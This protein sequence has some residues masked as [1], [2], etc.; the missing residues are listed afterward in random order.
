MRSDV[1]LNHI[2]GALWDAKRLCLLL[3]LGALLHGD[4][5]TTITGTVT[6]PPTEPCAGAQILLRNLA[7]LVEDTV[8]TNSEGV[9]E[10]PHCQWAPTEC[11]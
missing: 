7:T 9:Y 8:T 10:A 11:K 5:N 3:F 6:D 4:S 2:S 1:H